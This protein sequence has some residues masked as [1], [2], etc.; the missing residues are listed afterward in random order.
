M[1][2]QMN[3][4]TGQEDRTAWFMNLHR[5]F[6]CFF[7]LM[8]VA[9]FLTGSR[10]EKFAATTQIPEWAAVSFAILL[11]LTSLAMAV[12]GLVRPPGRFLG[13]GCSMVALGLKFDPSDTGQ[14]S[15]AIACAVIGLVGEIMFY[16]YMV[17]RQMASDR[18]A[19][20]G[21]FRE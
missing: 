14:A 9:Y 12:E 10:V 21:A 7:T 20:A 17:N 18:E 13:I 2:E 8:R 5:C 1:S 3:G 11:V 19:G 4:A 16:R 6:W 15:V